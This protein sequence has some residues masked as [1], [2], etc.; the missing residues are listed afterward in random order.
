ME[1]EGTEA[2]KSDHRMKGFS[3]N[4]HSP[5]FRERSIGVPGDT[6]N[7]RVGLPDRM[8]HNAIEMND[9]GKSFKTI[10]NHIEEELL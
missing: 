4:S 10:A 1:I 6:F 3:T 9:A 5:W 8:L 7:K 2:E